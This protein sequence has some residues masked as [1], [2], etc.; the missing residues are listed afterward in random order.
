M[1]RNNLL[2][3][4]LALSAN[5]AQ[6]V[7]IGFIIYFLHASSTV[8][9]AAGSGGPSNLTPF[10]NIPRNGRNERKRMER[11]ALCR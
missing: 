8:A 3:M 6:T 7:Y 9:F 10:G 11:W 2:K 4:C 1:K 5:S